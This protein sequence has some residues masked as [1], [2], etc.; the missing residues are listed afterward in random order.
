MTDDELDTYKEVRGI[1]YD[2]LAPMIADIFND[3][4]KGN[5]GTPIDAI[6]ASVETV[7]HIAMITSMMLGIK[8]GQEQQFITSMSDIFRAQLEVSYEKASTLKTSRN[9]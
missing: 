5:K 4:R 8:P 2:R 6:H 7:S 3:L 1:V 9:P